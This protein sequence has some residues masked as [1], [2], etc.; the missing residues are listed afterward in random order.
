V[1]SIAGAESGFV[2]DVKNFSKSLS[3]GF[4]EVIALSLS[5][6]IHSVLFR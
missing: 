3:I 1:F 2:T 6:A 4:A 5:Q